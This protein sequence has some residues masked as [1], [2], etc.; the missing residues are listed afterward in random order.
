[1]WLVLLCTFTVVIV[2]NIILPRPA[3]S[4]SSSPSSSTGSSS[5]SSSPSPSESSSMTVKTIWTKSQCDMAQ[6]PIITTTPSTTQSWSSWSSS[7]C[8]CSL[9]MSL[10]TRTLVLRIVPISINEG[11]L[12]FHCCCD[13]CCCYCSRSCLVTLAT[14]KPSVR[15]Q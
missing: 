4:S 2:I 9:W 15:V 5:S 10:V 7:C 6:R 11:R 12:L 1:M 14:T 13:Y 8:Y 3:S